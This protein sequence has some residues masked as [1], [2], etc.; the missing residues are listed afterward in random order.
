MNPHL[1]LDPWE[2]EPARRHR[3]V[4]ED[5]H[6]GQQVAVVRFID[7]HHLLHGLR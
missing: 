5:L 3:D 2:Q 4:L 6:I 1:H 7:T